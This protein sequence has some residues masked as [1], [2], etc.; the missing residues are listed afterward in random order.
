MSSFDLFLNCTTFTNFSV[1]VEIVL[2]GILTHIFGYRM[3]SLHVSVKQD[4]KTPARK[5]LVFCID[6]SQFIK[7]LFTLVLTK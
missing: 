6:I 1:I 4:H 2:Y 3:H 5:G 7:H